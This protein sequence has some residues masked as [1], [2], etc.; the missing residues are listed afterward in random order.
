MKVRFKMAVNRITIKQEDKTLTV[1]HPYY[2]SAE[3]LGSVVVLH[4]MAEHHE[5]YLPFAEYL[6]SCGYDVFLY[7]HRG[8]GLS[9]KFEDLGHFADY[10]GYKK[11]ICDAISVI[12]YVKSVNR[13]AKLVLF[14]HS[15]GSI[16]ARNVIHYYDAIDECIIC[17]TCNP[18]RWKSGMGSLVANIVKHV[19]GLHHCSPFLNKLVID[20]R[21][22]TKIS[23]R[24][25]FDWLTRDNNIVGAY[26]HDPYCGF[27]CT[28]AFY[29]DLIRL[30]HM[31][32]APKLI[33]RTRR[34][35]PILFIAGSHDP[36]GDFSHGVTNLFST[37]QRYGFVNSDCII[38]EECRHELLNE[39]NNS[40]IMKDIVD[41]MNKSGV[42]VSS[43]ARES[44][45]VISS[46]GS[47]PDEQEIAKQI[48]ASLA[49]SEPEETEGEK[50]LS[51]LRAKKQS[52]KAN[53]ADSE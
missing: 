31:A 4:G 17:G 39:L 20:T 51:D 5:R 7:D 28:T 41:W 47:E 50:K 6:N 18:P 26:I 42:S 10:D 22:F 23:N 3:P 11:V 8:H 15:M 29:H 49:T 30:T 33:K 45:P 14:G 19:K 1:V 52:R 34:E 48:N 9:R 40:E 53:K 46:K 35:L 21:E 37:F 25:A 38:Y 43:E 13:G 44:E 24:T 27:I 2:T 32:S 12:K 36:V 16:I